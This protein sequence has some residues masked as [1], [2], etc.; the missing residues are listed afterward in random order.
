MSKKKFKDGLESLFL[1]ERE[2]SLTHQPAQSAQ[3]EK[4][5]PKQSGGSSSGKHFSDELESFF[6]EALQEHVQ[7]K[8][9][10]SSSASQPAKAGATSK[11]K[12]GLDALIRSTLETSKME[13]HYDESKKRIAISFDKEKLEKLKKIARL[14]RTLLKDMIT[15]VVA[16]Y[17]EEYEQKMK[18]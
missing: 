11:P 3:E 13:L 9:S 12:D 7:E 5:N 1:D 14:E 4:E 2:D 8:R 18:L 15:R 6:Q 16:E 10:T 17:V